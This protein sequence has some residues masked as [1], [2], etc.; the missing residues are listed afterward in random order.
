MKLFCRIFICLFMAIGTTN[1][2]VLYRIS[3]NSAAAPSYILATHR[4]VDMN[5]LDPIPNAFKC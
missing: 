5:S 2:Q 3:G 1:A 4:V